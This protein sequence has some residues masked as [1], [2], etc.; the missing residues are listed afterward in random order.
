[1]AT[2]LV[3]PRPHDLVVRRDRSSQPCFAR[4][5]APWPWSIRWVSTRLAAQEAG[6]FTADG[7]GPDYDGGG[8]MGV[9]EYSVWINAT[10]EQVWLT[11]VDPTASRTGR[12]GSR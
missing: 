2:H 8:F 1:M 4:R 3:H 6:H 10:P 5:T 9:L 11:Y 12:P 7:Q